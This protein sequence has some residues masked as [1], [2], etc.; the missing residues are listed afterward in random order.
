MVFIDPFILQ[1]SNIAKKEKRPKKNKNASATTSQQSEPPRKPIVFE[2]VNIWE[3]ATV[4]RFLRL[5]FK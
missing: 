4:E 2:A 3:L 1:A 5:V